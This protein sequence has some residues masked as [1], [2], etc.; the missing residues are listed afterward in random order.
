ML[1]EFRMK[2]RIEHNL[3]SNSFVDCGKLLSRVGQVWAQLFYNTARVLGNDCPQFGQLLQ[4]TNH[5]N[6]SKWSQT[7][8]IGSITVS[9]IQ[10]HSAE[11]V[12]SCTVHII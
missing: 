8:V 5:C 10:W 12:N 11:V 7:K 2:Q 6:A 9:R 1:H 3:R 4:D